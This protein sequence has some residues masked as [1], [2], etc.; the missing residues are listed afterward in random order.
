MGFRD[1]NDFNK[2][3]LAKVSWR[4]IKNPDSLMAKMLRGRYF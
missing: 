3:M 4:L 2:A 1:L